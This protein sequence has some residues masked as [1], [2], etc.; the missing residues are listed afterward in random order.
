[1]PSEDLDSYNT[2]P[3]SPSSIF[4][5]HFSCSSNRCCTATPHT[6][7]HRL[8]SS[9]NGVVCTFATCRS[10]SSSSCCSRS[11][12]PHATAES[13][14][15]ERRGRK[16][17]RR[18]QQRYR[19]KRWKMQRTLLSQWQ[20]KRKKLGNRMSRMNY[21]GVRVLRLLQSGGARGRDQCYCTRRRRRASGSIR[22]QAWRRVRRGGP[23]TAVGAGP[24]RGACIGRRAGGECRRSAR[25]ET[26]G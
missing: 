23:D 21:D 20:K 5:F 11:P 8:Q 14:P 13:A 10:L 12:T 18:R 24:R 22:E 4:F 16:E 2:L 26:A 17:R 25:R 19:R 3:A 1:M 15:E 6:H 7:A 9:S